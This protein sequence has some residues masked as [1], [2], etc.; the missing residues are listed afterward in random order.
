MQRQV[1]EVGCLA[2]LLNR[3]ATDFDNPTAREW[4]LLAVRN[5]C[6]GCEQNQAYIQSLTLGGVEL[7]DEA[8]KAEGY[9]V[10]LQ[11]GKFS[12]EKASRSSSFVS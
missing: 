11:N 4:A 9:S 5:A 2:E 1:L 3:C 12:V 7:Q 6:E 8:L 10:R